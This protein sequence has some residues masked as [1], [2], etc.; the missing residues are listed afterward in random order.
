MAFQVSSDELSVPD[1][2][3]LAAMNRSNRRLVLTGKTANGRLDIVEGQVVHAV[4]GELVGEEAVYS[5]LSDPE[6]KAQSVCRAETPVQRSVFQSVS[7]LLLESAR[8]ADEGLTRTPLVRDVDVVSPDSLASSAV[9][10]R[11][12]PSI[13]V[14][15]AH[16]NV[17]YWAAAVFAVALC[18]V[19]LILWVRGEK[20]S[21]RDSARAVPAL[22]AVSQDTTQP[23][24]LTADIV[25]PRPTR[26]GLPP[27]PDVGIALTPTI[28]VRTLVDA[29]GTV[30]K[31]QIYRSRL[32]LVAFEDVA[33]KYVRELRFFPAE[34]AG[35]AVPVWFNFPVS[36]ASSTV[37]SP[38]LILSGSDTIGAALGPDLGRKF[39]EKTSTKV[40]VHAL[41]S[42]TAFSS[43]FTNS[44]QI[45]ASSRPITAKELEQAR[46]LGIELSEFVLGYD[47]IA[48]IVHER[49]PRQQ[50]TLA[51]LSA[52]FSG[53]FAHAPSGLEQAHL[54]GRPS[55]SG[56]HSF[57]RSK[58]L[59]LSDD[60]STRDFAPSVVSLEKSEEVIEHVANDPLG[61]G[62]VG[63]GTLHGGVKVLAVAAAAGTSAVLPDV[64]TIRNG[65]YPIY[66][67]LL[68]YV[69]GRP[70][71]SVAEFLRFALSA[72]GQAMVR[73]H[74]FVSTDTTFDV[75][76]FEGT[77]SA[78]TV[79]NRVY[80]IAFPLGTIGCDKAAIAVLGNVVKEA[81]ARGSRVLVVGHADSRGQEQQNARLAQQRAERVATELRVLGISAERITVESDAASAPLDTNETSDGR[82]ANRRVE[83]FL[84]DS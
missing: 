25:A 16:P 73:Q 19:G 2:L 45:G 63:S 44:A 64:E 41:G 59:R 29:R 71:G 26:S 32:E 5:A 13:T 76:R 77:S 75:A 68:L 7:H 46:S 48:V 43:L 12:T 30:Q 81:N 70:Q 53:D 57:F 37:P 52:V 65:R 72:E 24:E 58:V 22:S 84:I 3:Q 40:I 42:A 49:N 38:P 82:A 69:R 54:Y 56:T 10:F 78:S 51:E 61:I 50:V 66:R 4:F 17:R 31:A 33:V 15:R 80:R 28:V 9:S 35:H 6:L 67:P 27:R 36:F 8:R 47:G 18:V 34:K 11:P 62:Y 74:G 55:Y 23:M 79:S 83:V 21:R 60:S 1:L 39:E 14:G 20:G